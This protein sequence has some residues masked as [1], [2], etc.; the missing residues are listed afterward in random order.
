MTTKEVLLN[1]IKKE[2]EKTEQDIANMFGCKIYNNEKGFTQG[3]LYNICGKDDAVAD[4]TFRPNSESANKYGSEITVTFKYTRKERKSLEDNITSLDDITSLKAQNL[5]PDI[6]D[7]KAKLLSSD[8]FNPKDVISICVLSM[9]K[10]ENKYTSSEHRKPNTL[11]IEF[12][13]ENNGDDIYWMYEELKMFIEKGIALCPDEMTEY[14][15]YK[16]AIDRNNFTD[17]EKKIV[18]DESG[19]VKNK[20]VAYIFLSWKLECNTI[21]T[22]EADF[23]KKLKR[24]SFNKK[25]KIINDALKDLG[26]LENYLKKYPQ[27]ASLLI[28]KVLRFRDIRYNEKGKHLLYMNL[29]SFIHIY[30]RHVEELSTKHMYSERTKFQLDESDVEIVIKHVMESLNDEYQQFK[31]EHP[32]WKFE[33]Y[34]DKAYYYNGDYYHIAVDKNGCLITFYKEDDKNKHK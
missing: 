7:E 28:R 3:E 4:I 27:K 13:P 1:S 5:M 21:T 33:R 19:K 8:G 30:L 17:E 25:M 18:F 23:L 10:P 31:D 12:E 16:L 24:N 32:D 29:D 22:Y 6:D 15:A 9:T 2:I 14:Y 34:N 26:G 11:N 20:D